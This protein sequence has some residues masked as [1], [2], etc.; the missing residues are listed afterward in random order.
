MNK[1]KYQKDIPIIA[2]EDAVYN[3]RRDGK[4]LSFSVK[5]RLIGLFPGAGGMTLG[6]TK[7]TGHSFEPVWANDFNEYAVKTYNAN[8]RSRTS[9]ASRAR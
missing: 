4:L 7:L 3:A 6:F 9:S 5:P 2:E 1:K 8:F